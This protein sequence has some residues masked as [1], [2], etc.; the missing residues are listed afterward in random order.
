MLK[1]MMIATLLITPILA[2]N[3][4]IIGVPD[5]FGGI[6]TDLPIVIAGSQLTM[7]NCVDQN[8]QQDCW[9]EGIVNFLT[10]STLT[11]SSLNQTYA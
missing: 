10:N 3:N 2:D 1:F 7:E 4:T 8:Q 11:N 5:D 9:F 6:S